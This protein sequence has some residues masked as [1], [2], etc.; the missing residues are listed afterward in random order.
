M[1]FH[2]GRSQ[3][4]AWSDIELALDRG[5]DELEQQK[6]H[7]V[8]SSR[9]VRTEPGGCELWTTP[10]GDFWIPAENGALFPRLLQDTERRTHH[11]NA[12]SCG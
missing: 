1:L 3:A 12:S 10:K 8:E 11:V 7:F 2:L 4:C 5:P 6:A 9:R